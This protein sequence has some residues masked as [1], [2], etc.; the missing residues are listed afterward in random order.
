[1]GGHDEG[2]EMIGYWGMGGRRVDRVYGCHQRNCCGQGLRRVWATRG[3]WR[4]RLGGVRWRSRDLVTHHELVFP[5]IVFDQSV[6]SPR[7]PSHRIDIFDSSYHSAPYF[8][9]M[10]N[11]KKSLVFSPFISCPSLIPLLSFV[12]KIQIPQKTNPLNNLQ[13]PPLL[14]LPP[15]H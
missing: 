4:A 5:T 8:T 10:K 14:P 2:W 6:E 3:Q 1:V 11:F 15:L 12:E 7:I 13:R 9:V